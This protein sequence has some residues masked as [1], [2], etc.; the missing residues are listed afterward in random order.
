MHVLNFTDFLNNLTE[1]LNKVFDDAEILVVAR[2][3]GKNVVVM[4][5]DE[6]NSLM[7]TIYLSIS[8]ENHKKL[9]QA[10]DEV[11]RGQFKKHALIEE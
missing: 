1:N 7:E 11:K 6:Y 8:P 2:S 9:D 10:I 3:K 4:S 5:M